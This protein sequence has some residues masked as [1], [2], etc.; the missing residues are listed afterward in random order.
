MPTQRLALVLEPRLAATVLGIV[1]GTLS[2]EVVLKGRSP[3]GERVGQLVA[4]PL[5]T[6][7]DDPT[8][9]RSLGADTWDG[10]GLA[11]RR[12]VLLDAGVLRGFL[13]NSYTRP[14]LGHGARP[15]RPCGVPVP[16][17][18]WGPRPWP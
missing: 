14:S 6:L 1:A 9:P 3:F 17:P 2:G 12:N 10:E 5:L 7:V 18:G 15:V 13:H 8:D 4:S 16:C 11:C